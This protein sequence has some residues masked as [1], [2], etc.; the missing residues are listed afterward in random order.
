MTM[1]YIHLNQVHR[2]VLPYPMQVFVITQHHQN[3]L[4]YPQVL[5]SSSV[6]ELPPAY[7]TVTQSTDTNCSTAHENNEL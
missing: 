6:E 7:N 2:Q 1:Y 3:Q 5:W 4:D